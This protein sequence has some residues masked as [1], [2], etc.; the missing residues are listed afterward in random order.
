MAY[1]TDVINKMSNVIATT[2]SMI[3]TL[4]L[5]REAISQGMAMKCTPILGQRELEFFRG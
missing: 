3:A 2:R 1:L 4:G 5:C